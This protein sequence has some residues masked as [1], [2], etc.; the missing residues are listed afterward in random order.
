[1]GCC[2]KKFLITE[3]DR[4][5]ILSLYGLLKEVEVEGQTQ[6]QSTSALKFDKTINFAPGYYRSKGPVTTKAGTTYNWD[7]D[8]TLKT[9]L[10]KVKEFLKKNPTGYIVEVNLYSG[11]SQIP[12]NDNEQGGV[13][14]NPGD[15][16]T[17]RL[18]SLKTYIDPIFQ[19]WKQEGITQTDFKINEYKEIGKT[20]WIGTPFCPANTAEPRTCSTTYY[21]KVKANDKVALEYKTKYDTEQYFR[22]IIEVK[23]KETPVVTGSTPTV[24]GSTPTK[25]TED[26]ATGLKIRVDVA[27]HECNNAEFF[28]FLNDTLLYNVDGGYTANGNNANTFV[29]SDSGKKIR[30]KRLNPG[31]GKI[32]TKKYGVLGDIGNVRYDEFIVT[33]EQSKEI[34]QKS[35]DGKINVWYIC[36]FAQGCHL[37]TPTVRIYKNNLPIYEG[38]PMSDSSLLITLDGCGNEVSSQ[39]D[40]S[41]T[42]PDTDALRQKIQNDRMSMV[43]DNENDVPDKEDTKQLQLKASNTLKTMMDYIERLFTHPSISTIYYD[44]GEKLKQYQRT[45]TSGGKEILV[46]YNIPEN[47][48]LFN[49]FSAQKE[50]ETLTMYLDEIKRLVTQNKYQMLGD[51]FVDKNL[52]N[53][54]LF[55]DVRTNLRSFYNQFNKLFKFD[56]SGEIYM[57]YDDEETP[58]DYVRQL[59]Q[60]YNPGAVYTQTLKK[61]AQNA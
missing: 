31:Y 7:F 4:K 15:L 42:E 25:I 52:R 12:N 33:A 46:N 17:S 36:T 32:G 24:T 61:P 56:E 38:Q 57:R 6:Q 14:V 26:C 58:Y 51:Q 43:I 55:E 20:P 1:M 22:V 9:D 59:G 29:W 37:D 47:K 60:V 3:D 40:E 48:E 27:K 45:Y 23:K 13:K 49:W 50:N 10:E 28:V 5:H 35:P 39:V 11:E 44:K 21:N 19:S 18:N 41:A 2:G 34:I 16:N 54:A 53:N 8:Q 30:A